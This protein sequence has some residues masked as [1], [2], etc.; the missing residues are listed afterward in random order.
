MICLETPSHFKRGWPLRGI[1][2][3][4]LWYRG[5][6]FDSSPLPSY[7]SSR[8]HGGWLPRHP[9]EQPQPLMTVRP[10]ETRLKNIHHEI[11]STTALRH[12]RKDKWLGTSIHD[13]CSEDPRKLQRD[14]P[15]FPK[16]HPRRSGRTS[17]VV[18]IFVIINAFLA[19]ITSEH[20]RDNNNNTLAEDAILEFLRISL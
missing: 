6:S 20:S 16:K 10:L 12:S 18:F 13:V 11:R 8:Y 19:F 17:R 5:R 14:Q 3:V 7:S 1:I 2:K 4:K 15:L 9:Q